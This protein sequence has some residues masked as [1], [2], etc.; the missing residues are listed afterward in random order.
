[1]ALISFIVGDITA[2]SVDAIIIPAHKH[3]IRGRGLSAQIFDKAGPELERACAQHEDCEVGEVRITPGFNLS[4]RH[5]IHAV[6]PQWSGGDQ[7]G[8]DALTLLGTCYRRALALAKEQQ[9]NTLP[10]GTICSSMALGPWR[11]RATAT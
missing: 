1:M 7:Y 2:L 6:S 4:A 3:L 10:S 5:I 8:A 11:R 9:M